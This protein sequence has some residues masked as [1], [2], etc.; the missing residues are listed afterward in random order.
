VNRE[1]VASLIDEYSA[2]ERVDYLSWGMNQDVSVGTGMG[3]QF[4]DD[5]KAPEP[6]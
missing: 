5:Y 6:E 2:S 3:S 1:V 4:N